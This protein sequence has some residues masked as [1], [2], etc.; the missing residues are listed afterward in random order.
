V[1]ANLQQELAMDSF[2]PKAKEFSLMKIEID[3]CRASVRAE[4]DELKRKAQLYI[5]AFKPTEKLLD[6]EGVRFVHPVHELAVLNKE[7]SNRLNAY[8]SLTIRQHDGVDLQQLAEEE[9]EKLAADEENRKRL[10]PSP[11][12][13]RSVGQKRMDTCLY[14]PN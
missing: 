6:I 3:H 5:E 10:R 13:G 1:F 2:D 11:A 14:L 4:I 12:Y 9:S 8:F 7:R